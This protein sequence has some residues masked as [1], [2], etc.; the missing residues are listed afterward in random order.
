MYS[1]Y[2]MNNFDDYQMREDSSIT[3][4]F[5]PHPFVVDIEKATMNNDYFR[6]AL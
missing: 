2:D 3:T 4:D 6:V 5:G 1:Y